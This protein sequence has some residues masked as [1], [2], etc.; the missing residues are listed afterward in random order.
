MMTPVYQDHDAEGQRWQLG[1]P[2][3]GTAGWRLADV[4]AMPPSGIGWYRDI[5][6]Q[7][8]PVE[9]CN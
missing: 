8:S 5:H 3:D 7:M 4:T 2:D 1:A 6:R 9:V